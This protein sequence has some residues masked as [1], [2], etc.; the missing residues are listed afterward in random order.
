MNKDSVASRYALALF[1]LAKEN[2]Q[3]ASY[4]DELNDFASYLTIDLKTFLTHYSV[5]LK[6]KKALMAQIFKDN[7]S[8]D[9]YNFLCLLLD[10]QRFNS[11]EEIIKEYN[12]AA[13][14][15]LNIEEGIIYTASEISEQ[16]LIK[17]ENKVSQLLGKK[18]ILKIKEDKTL[19]GGFKIVVCDTVIDNS[20]KNKL[21]SLRDE[22]LGKEVNG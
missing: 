3:V 12:S 1:E 13:N 18:T 16:T 20:L 2:N 4:K 21:D 19:I 5:S 15:Y 14:E 8:S 11:I 10:K 9:V 6:D 17:I 7:L 22:L